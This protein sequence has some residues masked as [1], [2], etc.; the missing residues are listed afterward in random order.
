LGGVV[1][2]G[3]GYLLFAEPVDDAEVYEGVFFEIDGV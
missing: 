1:Y 2:G 3:T